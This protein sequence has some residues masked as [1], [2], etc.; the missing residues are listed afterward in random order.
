MLLA[1]MIR[2]ICILFLVVFLVNTSVGQESPPPKL[3]WKVNRINLGTLLEEEGPQNSTFVYTLIQGSKFAV[4]EVQ[5]DCGCTTVSF[6]KDTLQLEQSE[7]I[8]V[9]FDPSAATGFFSKLVVVRGGQGQVQDSLFVEGI[10]IPYPVDLDRNYPV[11]LGQIGL[12]LRKI[13]MGEVFDNEPKQK[14]LEFF[15]AG[16]SPLTKSSFRAQTPSF[17]RIEQVQELVRPKERGL[18]KISYDASQRVELGTV[19]D[20]IGISWSSNELEMLELEVLA[21]LFDY[22]APIKREELDL[23]PQLLLDEKIVDLGEISSKEVQRKSVTLTNLGKEKLEFRKLQGNCACLLLEL[24]VNEL[25]PGETTALTLVF[26]PQGRKG[27]DQRNIYLFTNDPVNPVQLL[28]L[29]SR[30]K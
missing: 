14:Y 3:S 22:F 25:Y 1:R 6:S 8:S 10:A 13:N 5:T 20:K 16:S 27:I 7:M 15:N 19:V 26:D 29:K 21:N 12:R 30:I 9:S 17:I 28:V 18:L 23:V 11:K 4:E 24:P 2:L